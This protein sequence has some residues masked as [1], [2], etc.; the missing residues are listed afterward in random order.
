MR[1]VRPNN[2]GGEGTLPLEGI[3]E[4]RA[5]A[6]LFF[7]NPAFFPDRRGARVITL[8]AI[9]PSS[10]GFLAAAAPAATANRALAASG[11]GFALWTQLS[12]EFG[13]L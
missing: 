4:G 6:A 9:F 12:I 2:Y 3:R 7:D 1:R 13:G 11:C 5:E 8:R 10:A